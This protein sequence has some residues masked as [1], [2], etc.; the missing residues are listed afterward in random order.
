MLRLK[1]KLR[2]NES[3]KARCDRH[4]RYDPS[5][6]AHSLILDKCGTCKDICELYDAYLGLE[7]A[8]RLF[9]RRAGAWQNSRSAKKTLD[10]KAS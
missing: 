9:E 4:P 6:P 7:K 5:A 8:A 3:V 2:L 1:Y 10:T